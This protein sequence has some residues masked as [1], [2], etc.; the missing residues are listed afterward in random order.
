MTRTRISVNVD[1]DDA[2]LLHDQVAVEILG[3]LG[4]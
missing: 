3:E 1:R 4:A 2:V